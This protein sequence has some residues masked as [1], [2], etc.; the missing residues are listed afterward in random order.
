MLSDQLRRLQDQML[1][2]LDHVKSL[3]ELDA[4]EIK[5][6]G[7][8]GELT[9]ILRQLGGLSEEER[10][11]VGALANEIKVEGGIRTTAI[12]ARLSSAD[13]SSAVERERID[14]TE[15]GIRPPQ[16]HLHVTTQ[17]IR[18]FTAIFDRIGFAR[19]RYPEVDWDWYAFEV[20]NMPGDHP[21]R[22]EWETFFMEAPVDKKWG[23]M[24][25][26][27]HT[28]NGT[29]RILAERAASLQKKGEAI[30]AVN[31]SKTYRRQIDVTHLPMFHQF[32]GVF[33]DQGVSL[34]HL[35]GVLDY[36]ATSFFGPERKIRMRPFHFRF[37]EPSFEID[38]SCGV[39][40]GSGIGA[41]KAKCRTC[42]RGWLE[43]GGAGM[44]HPNVLKAAGIDPKVYSGLA[45]GWG[46]ERTYMMKEGMRLD[47]IRIMYK[48]DIR[49]L[50]QF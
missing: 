15:P 34:A 41:D 40:G 20:L 5:F 11:D 39:C 43:L 47:D 38:V 3:E 50:E 12:R 10:R 22:D 2:A 7:R 28:T 18:E 48:N 24:I 36:F 29:A 4:V 30:K 13:A 45:F 27:P 42:K 35:R 25:L 17:A 33:V 21:A 44:L 31:I 8:K 19:T 23:K 26:T 32:D 1:S 6:L 14:V 46:V 49:F 37:T 9:G 16:G